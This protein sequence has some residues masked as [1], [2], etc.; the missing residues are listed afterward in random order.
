ML[1]MWVQKMKESLSRISDMLSSL[2]ELI[3]YLIYFLKCPLIEIKSAQ[4]L[5]HE[6]LTILAGFCVVILKVLIQ[7]P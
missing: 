4:N 2:G 7:S 5:K 6:K 1:Y 3:Y